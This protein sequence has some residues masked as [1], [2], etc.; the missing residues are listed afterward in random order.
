MTLRN[1]VC[2][3]PLSIFIAFGN[4]RSPLIAFSNLIRVIRRRS[5]IKSAMRGLGGLCCVALKGFV[6]TLQKSRGLTPPSML[7][8]PKGLY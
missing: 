3:F 6:M 4:Y 2:N 1:T 5:R 8:R 7:F